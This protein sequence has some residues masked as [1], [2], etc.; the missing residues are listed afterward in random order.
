MFSEI[1]LEDKQNQ[2]SNFN[3]FDGPFLINGGGAMDLDMF[4]RKSEWSMI[5]N[6]KYLAF[7]DINYKK[8]ESMPHAKL[9]E[10]YK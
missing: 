7:I 2:F 10:L 4:K 5:Q 1:K 9:W 3:K 6:A 8:M